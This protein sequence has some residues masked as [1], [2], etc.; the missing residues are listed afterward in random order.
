MSVDVRPTS[1]RDGSRHRGSSDGEAASYRGEGFARRVGRAHRSDLRRRQSGET[2]ALTPGESLGVQ[3]GPVAVAGRT[4]PLLAQVAHVASMIV[5]VQVGGLAA[6]RAVAAVADQRVL[7]GEHAA[8]QQERKT[9][10]V[11]RASCD[12]GL[13]VAGPADRSQPV[14]TAVGVGWPNL[15]PEEP[16]LSRGKLRV[17]REA[18][19]PGVTPPAVASS[20][21]VFV[22]P[23]FTV[24]RDGDAS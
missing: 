19:L 16:G 2:L 10:G 21:G 7:V 23:Q 13:S 5:G 12:P 4:A 17:H 9:V 3:A 1:P 14:T 15:R 18:S 11:P 6:D 24:L 20:A 22:C 8:V